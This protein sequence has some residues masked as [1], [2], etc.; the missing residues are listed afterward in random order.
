VFTLGGR[1]QQ[2]YRLR[3]TREAARI[4]LLGAGLL[5]ASLATAVAQDPHAEIFTGLEAS[6]NAISGYLGAGY[7]F[8]KGLYER[9][10]RVRAVGSLG[11]YDYRGTL[12][13]AGSDLGTTFDGD[14]SYG[15]ALLGYQFRAETVILKLFAGIE[16]EDQQI[17]PR[18][19][20]NSVQG[21]AVGMKLQ[22]E[23]W[24]DLSPLWFLSADAAYG[25]AFQEYWSLARVGRRLGPRLSLG[26]EGGALGN[27][28]YDAGRGGGFVRAN[29]R[30]LELT[31]SGGF[32]GNYLEDE[33]SG[34]VSLGVY[35][36]F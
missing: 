1:V 27:E 25:T 19:P 31:L 35:R 36:A 33:P 11:R 32:T 21:S 30:A 29:L 8:G 17:S 3:L 10:W 28:E 5:F 34:Y 13:G 12:F 26:L 6:N 2:A 15:A 23:S 16:A 9:G 7:A 18:D 22:A 24:F 20:E 4:G 14:A